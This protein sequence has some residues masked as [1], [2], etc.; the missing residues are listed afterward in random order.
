MISGKIHHSSC[1]Y[2]KLI[3]ITMNG[4]YTFEGIDPTTCPIGWIKL[5]RL[6]LLAT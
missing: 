2:P 4:V 6:L 1:L 5:K 3:K